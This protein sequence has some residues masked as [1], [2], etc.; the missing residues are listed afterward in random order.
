MASTKQRGKV[1]TSQLTILTALADAQAKWELRYD[2]SRFQLRRGG[3]NGEA[4]KLSSQSVWPLIDCE[5]VE[6]R[7][8]SY[9]TYLFGISPLGLKSLATGGKMPVRVDGK[10]QIN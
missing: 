2:G 10:W 7:K 1:S 8:F 3:L 5:L 4:R 6:K 9:P